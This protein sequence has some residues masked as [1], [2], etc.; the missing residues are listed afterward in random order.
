MGVEVNIVCY[1][2]CN[3]CNTNLYSYGSG[4]EYKNYSERY[5]G[6]NIGFNPSVLEMRKGDK[7]MGK[8]DMENL[9]N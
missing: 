2:D 5:V 8:G 4:I 1:R 9:V 3:L 6:F 7:L